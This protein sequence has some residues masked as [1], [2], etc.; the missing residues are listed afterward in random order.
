[1]GVRYYAVTVSTKDQ[2]IFAPASGPY[3]SHSGAMGFHARALAMESSPSLDRGRTQLYERRVLLDTE[4][5]GIPGAEDDLMRLLHDDPVLRYIYELGRVQGEQQARTRAAEQPQ[6][7]P[8]APKPG[9]KGGSTEK[10]V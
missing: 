8:V 2:S 4:S 3:D 7:A 5:V 10:T 1:M 6:G 9:A